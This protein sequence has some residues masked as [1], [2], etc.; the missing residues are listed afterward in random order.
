[1]KIDSESKL[2]LFKDAKDT[3]SLSKYMSVIN[4]R[5]KRRLLSKLRLGVLPL[6]IEKGR[7]SNLLRNDRHCKLCETD[8]VEDEIHFLF[9]CPSLAQYRQPFITSISELQPH[10]PIKSYH[11]KIKYLYFNESVP[12]NILVIASNLLY[13]LNSARDTLKS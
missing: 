13:N 2:V 5:E 8:Q 3:L 9:T 1:M 10:F 7:R 11:Q 12:I 4:N 6:E